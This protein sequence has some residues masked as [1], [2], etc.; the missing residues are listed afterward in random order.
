ML[1]LPK[2][3]QK[4]TSFD[5]LDGL[6]GDGSVRYDDHFLLDES[7]RDD[8]LRALGSAFVWESCTGAFAPLWGHVES[9]WGLAPVDPKSCLLCQALGTDFLTICSRDSRPCDLLCDPGQGSI[10]EWHSAGRP[11]PRDR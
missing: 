9:L 4:D 5:T 2:N 6:V 1:H 10:R 8:N 11:I 7:Q 3:R